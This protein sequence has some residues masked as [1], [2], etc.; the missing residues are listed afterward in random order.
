V[1]RTLAP[2]RE[3]GA[4]V[5]VADGGSGDA[6]VDIA[7]P[8]ADLV[9]SAPRGRARQMNAGAQAALNAT[10][11]EALIFLHADTQLPADADRL[12]AHALRAGAAWGRFDVRI[13]GRSP[14]LGL[15]AR[16][17]NW[18][19]RLTGIATGDQAIFV[20]RAAWRELGGYAELP[21]MEDIEFSQRAKRLS[22]PACIA[23]PVSTSGRRWDEHGV[24]HTV[25]LMWR[26]RAA[27]WLGADPAAL[28]RRYHD[29]R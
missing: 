7:R 15:I 28:A 9:I 1:L 24:L 13:T 20:S 22:R 3:R 8:L 26:L 11:A 25:L 17:M 27:Y 2:L 23:T 6:S 14:A 21:L 18:R 12:V 29:V 5:V 16:T 4:F 10:A 19:S